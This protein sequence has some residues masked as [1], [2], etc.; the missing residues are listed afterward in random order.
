MQFLGLFYALIIHRR[1]IPEQNTAAK[2]ADAG[3][4]A[5]LLFPI[6]H[7]IHLTTP[8]AVSNSDNAVWFPLLT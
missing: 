4:A 6:N 8:T 3:F 7:Q 5:V 2:P 1:I